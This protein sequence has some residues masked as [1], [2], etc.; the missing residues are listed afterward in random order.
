MDHLNL[1]P[2]E[3][4]LL[5]VFCLS[6]RDILNL[7]NTCKTQHQRISTSERF[8]AKCSHFR[9]HL[10]LLEFDTKTIIISAVELVKSFDLHVMLGNKNIV[11]EI[12]DLFSFSRPVT[13]GDIKRISFTFPEAL[14]CSVKQTF[15]VVGWTGSQNCIYIFELEGIT[16]SVRRLDEEPVGEGILFN[17]TI[18]IDY[19]GQ[20]FESD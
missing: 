18:N 3:I 16:L 8:A 19:P 1:L 20:Y 2:R 10:Q 4:N 15:K 17:S 13:P 11:V 7:K 14:R 5:I 9:L 6:F 12:S